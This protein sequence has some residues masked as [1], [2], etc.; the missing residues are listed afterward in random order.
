MSKQSTKKGGGATAPST[1]NEATSTASASGSSL[2]SSGSRGIDFVNIA[3]LSGLV[4]ATTNVLY[5]HGCEYSEFISAN[6]KDSKMPVLM[7]YSLL[8]VHGDD[9]NASAFENVKT[10]NAAKAV[11]MGNITEEII[12]Q[13]MSSARK[14][15]IELVAC[16]QVSNLKDANIVNYYKSMGSDDVPWEISALLRIFSAKCD[17]LAKMAGFKVVI[18][19]STFVAY[20]V[21]S[22][23]T[24]GLI[25]RA[26]EASPFAVFTASEIASAREA[27]FNISDMSLQRAFSDHT[28]VK[29]CAVL[30]AVGSLPDKWYMAIKAKGRY[31]PGKYAKMLTILKKGFAIANNTDAISAMTEIAQ[32]GEEFVGMEK[33]TAS[34]I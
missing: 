25:I 1:P 34:L 17:N 10:V 32:L 11:D 6:G 28:I 13:T 9:V 12:M 30:E 33:G 19:S 8:V 20:H 16:T 26:S 18:E 7:S 5:A 31:A 27:M 21:T 3:G 29:T 14:W 4:P 2:G 22:A 23:S 15:Y 24:A